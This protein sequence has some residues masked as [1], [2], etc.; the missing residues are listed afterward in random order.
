MLTRWIRKGRRSEET[1]CRSVVESQ[2]SRWWFMLRFQGLGPHKE[3]REKEGLECVSWV[4]LIEKHLPSA[5]S[6]RH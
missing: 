4:R 6:K 2:E 3:R 5:K 1:D